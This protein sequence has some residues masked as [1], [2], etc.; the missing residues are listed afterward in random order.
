V[1]IAPAAP[2]SNPVNPI[3]AGAAR[4]AIPPAVSITA[5]AI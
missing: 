5:A 2:M 4:A 1:A 3:G